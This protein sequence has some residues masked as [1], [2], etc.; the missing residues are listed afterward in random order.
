MMYNFLKFVR[1]VSV[2]ILL[3]S[4]LMAV[5]QQKPVSGNLIEEI[6]KLEK[7]FE[8]DLNKM[9]AEF[10]FS[11]YAAPNAVIKRENDSLI[12]TSQGIKQYYSSE[13]YKNAK[14]Y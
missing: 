13:I 6:R 14:A 1:L 5:S 12:H 3:Y 8:E 2:I 11:K 9:G 4:S 7:Q 10:A